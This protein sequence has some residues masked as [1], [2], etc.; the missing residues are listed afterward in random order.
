M[1]NI[2]RWVAMGLAVAATCGAAGAQTYPNKPVRVIVPYAAGQGADAAA[3]VVAQKLSVNM[4]RQFIIDNRAGAGGNIGA[5]LVAKAVPDGYTLLVGSNATHAA[6][7]ALYSTLPFDPLKHFAPISYVGAVPM[8]LLSAPAFPASGI[9]KLIDMAKAKP[10]T[11]NVAV[12]STTARVVFELLRSSSG[13]DLFP[14]D[15]KSSAQAMTDLVGGTVQLNIDTVIAALPQV[16]SGTLKALAVSSAAR[17][18]SLPN[19]PTFAEAGLSGFDLAAWNVWL[20]PHGTPPDIV[21]K[22]NSEIARV[23]ADRDVQERLRALGYEP[24]APKTPAQVADFIGSESVKWGDL[25][26]K[27]GIKVE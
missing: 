25:I 22:L 3:R 11:I 9:R 21:A 5:D 15:Y 16:A 6:N 27:A 20:A 1:R 8:V 18:S 23:L 13:A 19:V 4:G 10:G 14:I 2:I 7:A 12:P 26:R 17:A 24:A